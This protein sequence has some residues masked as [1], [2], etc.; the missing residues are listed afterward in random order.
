[1]PEWGSFCT[2]SCGAGRFGAK[3]SVFLRQESSPAENGTGM[4]QVLHRKLWRRPVWCKIECL[5]APRVIPGQKWCPNGAISAPEVVEQG[6]LVQKRVSFCAKSH[7]RPKMVPEWGSF[8]TGTCGTG[9]FGAKK[10]VFMHQESSP[11]ENG[12]GMGQFPHRKLWS[13][14]VWC[15]IECLSAPRVIPGRKWCRNGASSAPEVV[16]QAGFVTLVGKKV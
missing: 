2:G 15:K 9:Q 3:K 4:G 11:A 12:A 13:R 14:A 10:S 6:G 16:E 5:S 1:V 7:P 8:R